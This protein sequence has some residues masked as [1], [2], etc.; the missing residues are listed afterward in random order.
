LVIVIFTAISLLVSY[1]IFSAIDT[2]HILGI[3]VL[4]A[5]IG[6]YIVIIKGIL[7][8]LNSENETM[9]K[10]VKKD[11]PIVISVLLLGLVGVG[12]LFYVFF[13]LYQMHP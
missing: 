10:A 12:L 4:L 9:R 3:C 5:Y 8:G 7:K 11:L 13:G 2:I 6:M 1:F